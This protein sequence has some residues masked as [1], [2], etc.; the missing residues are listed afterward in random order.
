MIHKILDWIDVP[1]LHILAIGVTFTNVEVFL[2]ITSLLLAIGYTTW[3]WISEYK[4]RKD[5][6]K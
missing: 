1:L 2:K 6:N 5:G 4:K 3:K